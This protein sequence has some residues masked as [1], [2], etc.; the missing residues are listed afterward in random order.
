MSQDTLDHFNE[1]FRDFSL[2][3]EKLEHFFLD[4][5]VYRHVYRRG[6]RFDTPGQNIG[7]STVSYIHRGYF[8]I[9]F[10]T[11]TGSEVFNGYM[12]RYSTLPTFTTGELYGKYMKAN[13]DDAVVYVAPRSDYLKAL[14][15]DEALLWHQL[16]EPIYRRNLNDMPRYETL[17]KSSRVQVFTYVLFVCERFGKPVEGDPN[18]IAMKYPPAMLDVANF[19]GIHP[20]NV[21][22]FYSELEKAGLITHS[23]SRLVIEDAARLRDYINQISQ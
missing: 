9:F 7:R 17:S 4:H 12:P 16:N 11:S 8:K 1:V 19:N 3:N 2:Y 13:V 15:G 21:S 20:N 23:R 5:Y 22:K 6:E 18:R 10:T 14:A